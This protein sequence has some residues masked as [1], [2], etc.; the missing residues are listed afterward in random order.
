MNITH[1]N[2]N[3]FNFRIFILLPWVQGNSKPLGKQTDRIM[4]KVVTLNHAL[5]DS[6]PLLNL[7]DVI[8]LKQYNVAA[9][10]PHVK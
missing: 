2:Y 1:G 9:N 5:N 6:H 10:I 8:K 7:S 3:Y 4:V